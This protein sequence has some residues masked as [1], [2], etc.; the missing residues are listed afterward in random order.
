MSC[1]AY[2]LNQL[3]VVCIEFCTFHCAD[4]R[5]VPQP[6]HAT[7]GSTTSI[8]FRCQAAVSV[9]AVTWYVNHQPWSRLIPPSATH[10]TYPDASWAYP[11]HTLEMPALREYNNSIVQCVLIRFGKSNILSDNVTLVIQ[12]VIN[13]TG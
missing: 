4:F 10:N 6:I 11:L 9:G 13:M 5:E 3:P 7:L 8:Q 1:N 2:Y 12:A